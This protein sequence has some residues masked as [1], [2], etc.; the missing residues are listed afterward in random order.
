[1]WH[2][3]TPRPLQ[4]IAPGTQLV[5]QVP[6]APPEQKLLH[7]CDACHWVQPAASATHVCTVFPAQR[8]APAV[9]APLHELQLPP[10]HTLP[11]GQLPATQPVHP[12]TTFQSHVSTPPAV[13]RDAPMVQPSQLVQAPPVQSSP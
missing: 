6:H 9:H 12:D 2:V 11:E 8:V 3:S 5:P 1:M 13:Q 7:V 4:R 10:W